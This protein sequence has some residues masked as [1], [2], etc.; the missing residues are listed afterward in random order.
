MNERNRARSLEQVDGHRQRQRRRDGDAGDRGLV[1]PEKLASAGLTLADVVSAIS[2]NN[3]RA[4]GG[5]VYGQA[6]E[7]SV[8]VRG[9]VS[10]FRRW[11]VCC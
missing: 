7:T 8:D 2:A 6:R 4:P 11:P 9:D 1:D 3:V 5:I 10:E